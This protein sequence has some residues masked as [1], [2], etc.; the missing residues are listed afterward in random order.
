MCAFLAYMQKKLYLCSD[1]MLTTMRKANLLFL[2]MATIIAF[3]VETISAAELPEGALPGVFNVGGKQIHFSIGNLQ[4]CAATD[5][6][7]FAPRQYAL[8]GEDGIG[9]VAHPTRDGVKSDNLMVSSTYDGWIDLFGFGTS[10]WSSGAEAY[11]PWHTDDDPTHYIPLTIRD[12]TPRPEFYNL[13]YDHANA[14]WGVYNPISNGGNRR[15]IWR[16]MTR[17]EWTYIVEGRPNY[18]DLRGQATI[19]GVHGMVLLPDNWEQPW[20]ASFEPGYSLGWD[21][22]EYSYSEW[23]VLEDAGAVFLPCAGCRTFSAGN[24]QVENVNTAGHYRTASSMLDGGLTCAYDLYFNVI[25]PEM[26]T[27][28]MRCWG[29]SVRLVVDVK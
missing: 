7:R 23:K 21:A 25:I 2:I 4:Y 6:W 28:H 12:S 22:N 5:T 20:G 11:Q 9:N 16:T 27:Y 24:L 18:L 3:S 17:E 8:I 10:G 29:E 19:N 13:D 14:D 15:G 1:F 26:H